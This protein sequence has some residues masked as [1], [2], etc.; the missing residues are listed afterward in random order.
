[1]PMVK[2]LEFED[3]VTFA[4]QYLS[5]RYIARSKE[6]GHVEWPEIISIDGTPVEDQEDLG[7]LAA[8]LLEQRGDEMIEALDQLLFW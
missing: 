4:G 5:V 2:S 6:V 8:A 7:P 1:M 3:V